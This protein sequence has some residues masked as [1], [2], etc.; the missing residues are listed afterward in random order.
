MKVE[1]RRVYDITLKPPQSAVLVD[2]LWPRGISKEKLI[3]VPWLKDLAPSNELRIWFHKNKNE[4]WERFNSKFY[5]EL[6]Q[7]RIEIQHTLS[8]YTDKIILLTAVKDIKKSHIPTL[9]DFLSK[10]DSP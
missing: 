1:I 4:R 5:N 7:N 3:D 9:R 6:L 10:I 2:R 8:A